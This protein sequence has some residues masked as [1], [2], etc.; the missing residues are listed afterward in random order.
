MNVDRIKV[1][2]VGQF[3]RNDIKRFCDYNL[4]EIKKETKKQPQQLRYD[5]LGGEGDS[6]DLRV[7]EL[8]NKSEKQGYLPSLVFH[9]V[10]YWYAEMEWSSKVLLEARLHEELC[11]AAQELWREETQKPQAIRAFGRLADIHEGFRSE[12][13]DK[14]TGA[15]LTEVRSL[16]PLKEFNEFIRHLAACRE[17]EE[18]A[19]AHFEARNCVS[20]RESYR[21]LNKVQPGYGDVRERIAE[22]DRLLSECQQLQRQANDYVGSHEWLKALA[23]FQELGGLSCECPDM[24]GWVDNPDDAQKLQKL[25]ET[26]RLGY[27]IDN[28]LPWGDPNPYQLF[29]EMDTAVTPHS[30][31]ET[32]QQTLRRLKNLAKEQQTNLEPLGQSDSERLLI[33]AVILPLSI[34]EESVS[35]V[36]AF[37]VANSY[38]PSPEIITQQYP[39]ES[40][41]LLYVLGYGRQAAAL[42]E[43]QQQE[44][45]LDARLAH[46]QGIHYWRQATQAGDATSA[47]ENW[48]YAI[49]NWAI[50]L[51]DTAYWL[52]WG[53]QRYHQ[54]GVEFVFTSIHT[55]TVRIPEAIDKWLQT[56]AAQTKD[57]G[58]QAHANVLEQLR[59][60]LFIEQA[61]VRLVQGIG[62]IAHT[63]GQQIWFGPLRAGQQPP[64]AE[65]LAQHIARARSDQVT[66]NPLLQGLPPAEALR[67]LRWYFSYL[68]K[69]AIFLEPS[70]HDPQKALEMLENTTFQHAPACDDLTCPQHG[71][72][73]IP[74]PVCC[75]HWEQFATRAQAYRYLPE[76]ANQLREDALRLAITAHAQLA[77]QQIVRGEIQDREILQ[78]EWRKLLALAEFS[79]DRANIREQLRAAVLA[80]TDEPLTTI[81][82]LDTLINLLIASLNL[83][84]EGDQP[85]EGLSL[86]NRLA[87]LLAR[88]GAIKLGQGD[89]PG[90]EADLKQAL[91][92]A[93]HNHEIRGQLANT[94]TIAA[95]ESA[96]TDRF[97]ALDYARRATELLDEGEAKY[98]G[99]D[100]SQIRDWIVKARQNLT[101]RPATVPLPGESTG[102][103]LPPV[104]RPSQQTAAQELPEVI[105]LYGRG[106]Q[107]LR[108]GKYLQA[109]DK[110]TEALEITPGDDDI[111]AQAIEA[112]L[113]QAWLL[114]EQGEPQAGL[115]LIEQWSPKLP[116]QAA[117]LQRQ[118]AFLQKW[119]EYFLFLREDKGFLYRLHD[120][121]EIL[122]PFEGSHTDGTLIRARVEKDDLI[123][124]AVLRSM[125]RPDAETVW[126]NLLSAC[127]EIMLVRPCAEEG[128]PVFLKSVLPFRLFA[129]EWFA[130]AV[131]ELSEFADVSLY[132]L[133]VI[134]RLRSGFRETRA[135]YMQ[136]IQNSR[137]APVTI[138]AIKKMCQDQKWQCEEVVA[139]SRYEVIAFKR[140]VQITSEL[141]GA[142]LAVRLGQLRKPD[143]QTFEQLLRLNSRFMM[144]KLSLGKDRQLILSSEWPYLDGSSIGDA[145]ASLERQ[146]TGLQPVLNDLLES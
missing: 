67:Q 19:S 66:D 134:D 26:A 123:L 116:T 81:P 12:W 107:F 115:G 142:R 96:P 10:E 141:D 69:A 20:A 13:R 58:D 64:L 86:K 88:R 91:A 104:K 30:S 145:F 73:R 126:H 129:P 103:A 130:L 25:V 18:Q 77:Q 23:T 11:L 62:G 7:I 4:D 89:I 45:P 61:A 28:T 24:P 114:I 139:N 68:G 41:A 42:W 85:A 112:L 72:Q 108:E 47:L 127:A 132:H 119:S 3:E 98:P 106:V 32:I 46:C 131:S 92:V 78:G 105:R 111:Q 65:A 144:E 14:G 133:L 136:K 113:A 117:R 52:R 5:Y 39:A 37:F 135:K 29:Q 9:L 122:L 55:L 16:G 57:G 36:E 15:N 8:I 109:L 94:W 51:A 120:Y 140:Q 70:L 74:V 59:Q 100:Y 102:E 43:R 99:H 6:P 22:I 118:F 17:L 95:S 34:S 21:E 63:S 110:F 40:A 146:L 93:P 49:S 54:Y 90:A 121:Q 143:R 137:F 124:T 31:M 33:D 48:R 80:A 97:L 138:E 125:P 84:A 71:P 35:G 79:Q 50:A 2:F 82:R 128:Q 75:P 60:D 38:L 101:L 53:R 27:A 44:Q 1:F 56:S 87:E 76:P 83:L